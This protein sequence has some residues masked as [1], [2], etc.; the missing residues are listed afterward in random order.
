MKLTTLWK[1]AALKGSRVTHKHNIE[2]MYPL[3]YNT[4]GVSRVILERLRYS[5]RSRWALMR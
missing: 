3:E 1:A 2:S 4:V 5:T